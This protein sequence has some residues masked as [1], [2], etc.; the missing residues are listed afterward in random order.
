[1]TAT[2]LAGCQGRNSSASGETDT[3]GGTVDTDKFAGDPFK[4]GLLT[5]DSTTPV[6]KGMINSMDLAVS[7]INESGGLLGADVEYLVGKTKLQSVRA[8]QHYRRFTVDENVDVTMGVVLTLRALM[9]AIAQQ[10]TLH[11]TTGAPNVFPAELVSRKVSATGMDPAKEYE[12]FKYHFRVGPFNVNQLLQGLVEFLELY[13][14]PLGWESAAVLIENVS[15]VEDAEK[16]VQRTAG[17]FLDLPIVKRVSGSISDWTPVWDE[18]EAADVDVALVGFALAGVNAITQWANQERPFELGGAIV[19]AMSTDFWDQTNGACQSVWTGNAVT[20]QSRNTP[21]TKKY[22]DAYDQ[23][24]GG[25]PPFTGPLTYD[26][27]HLYAQAVRET[28]SRDPEVLIPYLEEELHFTDGTIIDTPPGFRFQGPDARYAH[29]PVYTCISAETCGE[30]AMGVPLFQQ[31]QKGPGGG[32]RME[33]FA[34]EMNKT[35]SY[36]K[37]PWMR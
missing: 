4:L 30:Q 18:V 29:D 15:L 9:P 7:E 34:P 1:M 22:I 10:E 3:P 6:G 31:W 14:E 28:G 21:R 19:R 12:K 27:V 32:G 13:Q 37:P 2:A 8:K 33:V 35:A 23:A 24:Y 20:P 16:K 5:T 36:K 11:L 26:A 25:A 17:D